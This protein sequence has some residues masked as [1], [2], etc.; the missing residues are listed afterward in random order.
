LYA[1]QQEDQL[2]Q[3]AAELVCRDL[4]RELLG[5]RPSDSYLRAVTQLGEAIGEGGFRSIAGVTPDEI[6]MPYSS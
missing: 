4:T 5:K 1:A 2:V 6:L 3:Q